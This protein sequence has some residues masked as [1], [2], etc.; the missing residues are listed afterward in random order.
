MEIGIRELKNNLSRYLTQVGAGNEI[1][2]T[3]RG[4]AVA[5]ILPIGAERTIDRLIAEGL[6]TPAASRKRPAPTSRIRAKQPVAPLV[7][8]QRR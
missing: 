7:A 6:V 1:T 3:D 8:D 2:V 5:R 4:R